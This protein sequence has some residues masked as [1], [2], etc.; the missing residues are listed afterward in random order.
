M[1]SKYIIATCNFYQF[2]LTAAVFSFTET[3]YDVSED[4]GPA[5]VVVELS[6]ADL[7]FPIDVT[8]ETVGGGSA[9]GSYML[10]VV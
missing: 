8:V 5:V 2:P 7:T 4:A 1:C 3:S 10:F 9:T 6:R